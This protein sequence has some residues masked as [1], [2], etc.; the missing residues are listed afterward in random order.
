MFFS[1]T[2]PN[3]TFAIVFV[4]F[5]LG[6]Y[7]TEIFL[8]PHHCPAVLTSRVKICPAL[9]SQLHLCLLQEKV[10]SLSALAVVLLGVP[11]MLT[12]VV[13]N[14]RPFLSAM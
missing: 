3:L 2:G 8:F 11:S 14:K 9:F 7:S 4:F 13:D 10:R 12:S 6:Y 5:F 1:R